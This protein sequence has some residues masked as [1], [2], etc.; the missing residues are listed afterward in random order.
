MDSKDTKKADLPPPAAVTADSSPKS[1][2]KK[3]L[4]MPMKK[5]APMKAPAIKAPAR[6]LMEKKKVVKREPS[7]SP[8]RMAAA[9]PRRMGAAPSSTRVPPTNEYNKKFIEQIKGPFIDLRTTG[10]DV[11]AD[12]TLEIGLL[13]DCTGSMG[14]WID[15]AKKTIHEIIDKSIKECE[16]DGS[17]KC[18]VSFI[19]YRDINEARRFEVKPFSDNI[20]EVKKYI[21]EVKADGGADEPEDMQ[22]GLKLCLLQDWTEEAIKRVVIITDAPP[23]GKQYHGNR[24]SDD[25]P[26]GSPEGI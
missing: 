12:P 20:D 8:R 7:S 25:F 6:P 2:D 19:G 21:S 1:D 24:C 15:R 17:L 3:T 10:A 14:S 9:L 26:N 16:E 23:H 5:K 4:E 18:R 13:L 11:D 22:G